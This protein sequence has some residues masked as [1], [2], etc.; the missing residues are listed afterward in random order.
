[1]FFERS[2]KML[3]FMFLRALSW[4]TRSQLT[5][6]ASNGK[7]RLQFSHAPS[8]VLKQQDEFMGQGKSTGVSSQTLEIKE[9]HKTQLAEEL[10]TLNQNVV[11]MYTISNNMHT[12]L[13]QPLGLSSFRFLAGS[14]ILDPKLEQWKNQLSSNSF[15]IPFGQHKGLDFKSCKIQLQADS[16]DLGRFVPLQEMRHL[17]KREKKR[18]VSG[19]FAHEPICRHYSSFAQLVAFKSFHQKIL[20]LKIHSYRGKNM[21]FHC[22]VK[23]MIARKHNGF[24]T[25]L[26]LALCCLCSH[27]GNF[28]TFLRHGSRGRQVFFFLSSAA[29]AVVSTVVSQRDVPYL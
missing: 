18:L 11:F 15:I 3:S 10:A 6:C 14:P 4:P 17:K 21:M 16:K 1:M 23:T 13:T 20:Q 29:V 5:S 22:T 9:G 8:Q 12:I 28:S 26:K 7:K 2:T 24:H 27:R 19:T 25:S